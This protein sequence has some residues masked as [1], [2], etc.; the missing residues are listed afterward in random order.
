MLGLHSQH[1][2][3]MD[4]RRWCDVVIVL[5]PNAALCRQVV[6]AAD[7]LA[8][9]D[10]RPLLAAAHISSATP[11]PFHAVDIAVATPGEAVVQPVGQQRFGN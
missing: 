11:P 4:G 2:F 3:R 10:G 9:P 7:S 8:G 5:T 1:F 6:A